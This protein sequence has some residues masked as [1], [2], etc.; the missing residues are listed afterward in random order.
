M[1]DLTIAAFGYLR[2]PLAFAGGAFAVGCLGAALGSRQA[3]LCL[4]VM[5]LLLFQAARLAMIK[6][7]PYL[8][9]RPLAQALLAAPDG[10][11]IFDDQFYTFSSVAFYTGRNELLL[12]GRVNN[13]EYGSNA[14]DA[15]SVFISNTDLRRLWTSRDRYYLLAE[16]PAV[17]RLAGVVGRDRLRVTAESGGKYLFTNLP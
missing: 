15:L 2:L 16:G 13:L 4:I 17:S 7:D 12:N 1:G 9:S 14:P 11:L 5:M 10:R 3:Y 6:F 8:S